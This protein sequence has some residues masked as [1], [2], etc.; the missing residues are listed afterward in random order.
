MCP[1][2]ALRPLFICLEAA[3][4]AAG[5]S[6]AWRFPGSLFSGPV[7]VEE[8]ST[9][10]LVCLPVPQVVERRAQGDGRQAGLTDLQLLKVGVDRRVGSNGTCRQRRL[11]AEQR[12]DRR[13]ELSR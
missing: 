5:V 2:L 13:G 3:G 8:P 7:V 11:Q 6:G 9:R 4:A 12:S 1:H 10:V